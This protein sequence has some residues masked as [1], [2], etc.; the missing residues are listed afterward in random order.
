SGADV[1]VPGLQG[2]GKGLRTELALD[3][4]ERAYPP[5]DLVPYVVGIAAAAQ[6]VAVTVVPVFPQPLEHLS[7]V[8]GRVGVDLHQVEVAVEAAGC[9]T[10]GHAG[11]VAVGDEGVVDLH[12]ARAQP[13][14]L[15]QHL[16][17]RCGPR[18]DAE[19]R[20]GADRVGIEVSPGGRELDAWQEDH[21]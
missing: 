1:G 12:H 9:D 19:A 2:G 3:V 5:G 7:V 20:A 10:R 15:A 8:L 18:I 13:P 17:D 4:H 11:E 14:R 21:A 6:V 16:A